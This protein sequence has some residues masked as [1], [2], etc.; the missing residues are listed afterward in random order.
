MRPLLIGLVGGTASG[1]TTIS[2]LLVQR[3]GDGCS[4][5]SH[6]AYYK[7]LP[8]SYRTRPEDYN[9]DHP[10]ALES[11]RLVEDLKR[12]CDGHSVDVPSYDFA[13][14]LRRPREQWLTVASRPVILVEGILILAV[15][16][17]RALLDGSVFVQAAQEVRLARRLTRDVQ[18]RG[19]E[20]MDVR[21]QFA[22]TV[23]PM[24][25]RYVEPYAGAAGLLVDGE[26]DV[27]DS[28]KAVEAYIERLVQ[29][30]GS[31]RC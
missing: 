22:S 20:E 10:D 7:S 5:I 2:R 28:L 9:F 21:A 13:T 16:E 12:L 14:H 8:A 29:A 6:D 18:E 26:G 1:K 11:S 15:P 4:Y 31:E 3:L 24:H 30:R 25:D 17:L 19:R 23:A 27:E